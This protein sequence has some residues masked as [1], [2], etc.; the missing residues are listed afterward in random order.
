MRGGS[1]SPQ[2]PMLAI[3]SPDGRGFTMAWTG[4]FLRFRG[5]CALSYNLRIPQW[6][7]GFNPP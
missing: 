5:E 4:T 2:S 6:S 3:R 1:F 7:A